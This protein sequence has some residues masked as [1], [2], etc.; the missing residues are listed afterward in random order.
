METSNDTNYSTFFDDVDTPA[1]LRLKFRRET[2]ATHDK[3]QDVLHQWCPGYVLEHRPELVRHVLEQFLQ[4]EDYEGSDYNEKIEKWFYDVIPI[5]SHYNQ[6]DILLE[7]HTL[8][9]DTTKVLKEEIET[10]QEDDELM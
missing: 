9:K 2:F 8:Y 1:A 4:L 5:F 10:E 3:R 7:Y 6:G